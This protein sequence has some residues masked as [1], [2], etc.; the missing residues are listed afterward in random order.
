MKNISLSIACAAIMSLVLLSCMSNDVESG[1][2]PSCPETNNSVLGYR[3]VCGWG[4]HNDSISLDGNTL[5]Y[6]FTSD[7]NYK[8]VYITCDEQEVLWKKIDIN[9][10]NKI[11]FNTCNVCVD[12][13]DYTISIK[14]NTNYHEITVGEE[15][16][17]QLPEVKAFV[18]QLKEIVAAH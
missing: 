5:T 7:E 6:K 11:N 10:F 2:K 1:E 16:S 13:C 9:E 18:D 12:G 3:Y 14:T 8:Q 17:K 4:A 15:E